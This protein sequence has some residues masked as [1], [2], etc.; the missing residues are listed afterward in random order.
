MEKCICGNSIDD[1]Y[2]ARCDKCVDLF[3]LSN[4]ETILGKKADILIERLDKE[5]INIE[6]YIIKRDRLLRLNKMSGNI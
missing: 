4:E 1:E 3:K 2:M 6:C 5:L